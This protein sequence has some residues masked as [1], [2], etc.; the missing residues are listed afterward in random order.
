M[1]RS[2][3]IRVRI[4]KQAVDALKIGER[5]V[6]KEVSGFVAR[7]LPSGTAA[8]GFRYRLKGRDQR[9]VSLGEHGKITA[10]QARKRAKEL[11]ALVNLNRD[12]VAEDQA[13]REA[14]EYAKRVKKNT[15]NAVL[16]RFV[17][18]YVN[19][20]KELR[21][22]KEIERSLEQHVRP[23]IG[24]I[25]IYKLTR[26]DINPML[27]KIGKD[28]GP[29]ARDKALAYLR[30][31]FHW[32]Q[33]ED[34]RFVSPIVRGMTNAKSNERDRTLNDDEIRCL[35]SALDSDDIPA[36]FAK[37]VRAL[38]L[39]GQRRGDV[40]NMHANEIDGETWIIPAGRY[41]NA[42]THYVF[43]TEEARR[44]IPD[45]KGFIFGAATKGARPYSGFSKAKAALD[46]TMAR[47]RK[48]AK[49]SAIP[50]WTLHDLRRTAR[51]LMSRAKVP[52]DIAEMVIGHRL[53]G[54]RRVYDRYTYEDERKDALKRLAS[55]LTSI[56]NPA[57]NN[58]VPLTGSRR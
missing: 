31:A 46:K 22:A 58:V 52:A 56:V 45:G 39:T 14:E 19:G 6:D 17:K 4:T 26:D 54:V 15:V 33:I 2:E 53:Q 12:P 48:E 9:W 18:E 43:L 47:Q 27:R 20:E 8:Y 44:W 16:D 36:E 25:P 11:R 5:I 57:A 51:S 38:L 41:K 42:D 35:W 40:A 23:E 3:S 7:R 13:E 21:T 34:S 10:D 32:Y 24:T 50:H 29:R 49:L 55:L 37:I 28:A 30:K 1:A